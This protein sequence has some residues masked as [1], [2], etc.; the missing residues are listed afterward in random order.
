MS[1]N[2]TGPSTLNDAFHNV[3]HVLTSS[4][5]WT[6]FD[7]TP[8]NVSDEYSKWIQSVGFFP[9]LL[10][11]VL[12][13]TA[14]GSWIAICCRCKCCREVRRC[15]CPVQPCGNRR[16]CCKIISMKSHSPD[17]P[18]AIT[19]TVLGIVATLGIGA[20][21]GLFAQTAVETKQT[22]DQVLDLNDY[23]LSVVDS[24]R[25]VRDLTEQNDVDLTVLVNQTTSIN[26]TEPLRQQL[27]VAQ[28]QS[29]DAVVYANDAYD[30]ADTDLD[31]KT[32]AD[33]AKYYIDVVTILIGVFGFAIVLL[34]GAMVLSTYVYERPYQS[35]QYAWES[36]IVVFFFISTFTIASIFGVLIGVGD[37]C[38]DPN[39]YLNAAVGDQSAFLTYYINCAP[40]STNPSASDLRSAYVA[41]DAARVIVYELY[42]QTNTTY[43]DVSQPS[44]ELYQQQTLT[45]ASINITSVRAQCTQPHARLVT[46][47]ENVCYDLFNWFAPA[48]LTVLIA[49]N[50]FIV[51]TC[52]VP[53]R[54]AT[55]YK[56][57]NTPSTSSK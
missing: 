35:C 25:V 42:T 31:V 39:A 29:A 23:R 49:L 19:L 44:L 55:E 36:I 48:F 11:L 56:K 37:V 33:N 34:A 51:F 14:I 38:Q 15:F 22:V 53:R 28:D 12:L 20:S 17:E 10:F 2:F 5:P 30:A 47:Q 7:P 27:L 57:L 45:M 41:T 52:I 43:P 21:I 6:T 3:P 50:V 13:L 16:C 26:I 8:D 32:R 46:I 18:E 9:A 54:I 1:N 4:W 24:I 40:G